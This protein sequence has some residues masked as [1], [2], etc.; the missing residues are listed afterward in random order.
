MPGRVWP[1]GRGVADLEFESIRVSV[2]ISIMTESVLK[3]LFP[4]E[5]T[6]G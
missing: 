5:P 3:A 2:A 4:G 1:A 6:L